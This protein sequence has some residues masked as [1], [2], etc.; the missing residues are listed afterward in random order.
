MEIQ[1]TRKLLECGIDHLSFT[2]RSIEPKHHEILERRLIE[3]SKLLAEHSGESE[4]QICYPKSGYRHTCRLPLFSE[5]SH[6]GKNEGTPHLFIQ[7]KPFSD[8]SKAFLRCELKG[9]PL[10]SEHLLCAQIW[11]LQL[12]YGTDISLKKSDYLI[13][14][15]DVAIDLS[16]PITS[17]WFD[18]KGSRKSGWFTGS[19]GTIETIYIG[20]KGSK[21]CI[22]IY[23][24]SKEEWEKLGHIP[25]R[26][27]K[28]RIEFRCKTNCD[29]TSIRDVLIATKIFERIEIYDVV[30]IRQADCL[31]PMLVHLCCGIGLKPIL[32]SLEMQDRRSI[33]KELSPYIT[34][35]YD[36]DVLS[37]KIRVKL[38]RLKFLANNGKQFP[39][40]YDEA[41]EKF[42]RIYQL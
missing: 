37:L 16:C 20:K 14:K 25:C 39:K 1:M 2:L 22:C 19:D 8:N 12:C 28:T 21:L 42:R 34:E 30:K 36:E 33:R 7:M 32:Q 10:S 38:G 13:N 27:P 23:D 15:V 29:I 41:R 31:D 9:H 6:K 18:L 40:G 24:K 11:L 26:P 5:I 4:T 3:I 17:F 35:I